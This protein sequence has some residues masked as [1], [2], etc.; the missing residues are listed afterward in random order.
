MA[1]PKTLLQMAGVDPKPH[2]LSESVLLLIDMQNEYETG[3][4][5][6]PDVRAATKEAAILLERARA[7]G[8]PVVHVQHKGAPGGL[9]DVEDK[10]GGFLVDVE[11]KPGEPV[12]QKPRPNSFSDTNLQ[13]VLQGIGR[14]NLIVAG[15][16]THMCVSATVRVALD[17][18]Y[19]STVVADATATRDLPAR[20]GGVI[21]A[22]DLHE[23]ELT[24][25]SDRFA[26][27]ADGAA[28]IPD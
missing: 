14:K 17:L 16:M 18:G 28:D 26:V 27:I 20:N 3:A 24:A 2:R 12:V 1:Q 7:A 21:A 23:A 6:L 25:L 8:T 5:P 10:R 11:P 15:F 13:D 19:G 22:R 9:F 4:L